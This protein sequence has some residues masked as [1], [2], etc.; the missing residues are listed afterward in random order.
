[1][2]LCEK[3][4]IYN[5]WEIGACEVQ[6]A[7]SFHL[8]AK[9]PCALHTRVR[10]LQLLTYTLRPQNNPMGRYSTAYML[11]TTKLRH[12]EVQTPTNQLKQKTTPVQGQ[13][14]TPIHF[15]EE[16]RG[17]LDEGILVKMK[18]LILPEGARLSYSNF[19]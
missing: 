9:D 3:P 10:L 6:S 4:S 13:S 2:D 8:V 18:V 11:Q 1:M 5:W 7:C 15:K 14:R 12:R 16:Q 19:L 17:L